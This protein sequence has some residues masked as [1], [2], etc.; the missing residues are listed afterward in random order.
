MRIAQSH[1]QLRAAH[2]ARLSTSVEESARL[3]LGADG[4][5]AVVL[6]GEAALALEDD[7]RAGR[8]GAIL[9]A[10]E[11]PAWLGAVVPTE[12]AIEPA[13]I[14]FPRPEN[15]HTVGE[16]LA[17]LS[18]VASQALRADLP[19]TDK[20]P[21]VDESV[22]DLE[23]QIVVAL[24]ERMTGQR[25]R[26]ID[27]S[28]LQ[29]RT[30]TPNIEV[31]QASTGGSAPSANGV[32]TGESPDFSFEYHRRE[33]RAES[34]SLRFEADAIVE[35]A[36]GRRLEIKVNLGLDRKVVEESSVDV[37]AG[38]AAIKKDPLVLHFDG[39]AV[40][41]ADRTWQ[42][43]IDADG[44]TEQL[45]FVAQG[46]AFLALDKDGSGGID[47]G[48]ELFGAR[49]GDGFADLAAYDADG[50]QW[51]DEGDDVFSRLRIW[52]RDSS[53]A[54]SLLG[55]S[56]RGV[57]A[58]FLGKVATPF[59]FGGRDGRAAGELAATGIYLRE[60]GGAGTVHHLD[61]VL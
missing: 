50:N 6:T 31:P 40:A 28:D 25:M 13:A 41:L 11:T 12:A 47:N 18:D 37:L 46:S 58:I 54:D 21:D 43:D 56:A 52:S 24:F 19:I 57:G 38:R 14:N 29:A 32:A 7:A 8:L 20:T 44:T 53:G 15:V 51:I 4:E 27:A 35:T 10:R 34:E 48:S 3:E 61:L 5:D 17:A 22:G 26:F 55:L 36:D 1:V 2:E 9:T 39:P 59:S 60:D 30:T 42:F 33:I 16:T 49:S 45:S 23:L